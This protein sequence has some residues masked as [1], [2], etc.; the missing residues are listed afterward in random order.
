VIVELF[1]RVVEEFFH[2]SWILLGKKSEGKKA[3]QD[4]SIA[5]S[6][7]RPLNAKK[8]PKTRRASCCFVNVV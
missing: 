2:P 5:H 6:R 7:I 8:A 3:G 1:E 4:F